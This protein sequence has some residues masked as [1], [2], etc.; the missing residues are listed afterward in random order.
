MTLS[1]K[2][3]FIRIR[4]IMKWI[5]IAFAIGMLLLVLIVERNGFV[6]WQTSIT[7]VIKIYAFVVFFYIVFFFFMPMIWHYVQKKN[8]FD[9]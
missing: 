6:E 2:D 1:K 9:N 7:N 4:T 8:D 3:V 5:F